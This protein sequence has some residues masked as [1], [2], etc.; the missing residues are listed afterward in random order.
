[1]CHRKLYV[2]SDWARLDRQYNISQ[3]CSHCSI[4]SGQDSPKVSRPVRS[5]PMWLITD[6]C[7][8]SVELPGSTRMR[9]TSKSPISRDRMRASRCGCNI[10]VGFTGGKM[11]VPSM[12]RGPP[13]AISSRMELTC[14]CTDAA[15]NNLSFSFGVVFLIQW[16][17]VDIVYNGFGGDG[18][19][20]GP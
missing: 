1:M 5:R 6:A 3:G 12:G 4:E 14:S 15:R 7:K 20:E 19:P 2:E 11:I 10:C 13:P 18:D 17:S 16:P 8:R 9:L